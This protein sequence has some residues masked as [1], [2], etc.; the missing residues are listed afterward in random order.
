MPPYGS[1][2]VSNT[3]LQSVGADQVVPATLFNNESPILGQKSLACALQ[4]KSPM[5]EDFQNISVRVSC[6][7]GIGTTTIQVQTADFDADGEYTNE[8]TAI[9]PAD[10]NGVAGFGVA[11]KQ[12]QITRS[13]FL[14]V[15]IATANP[16]NPITVTVL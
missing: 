11:R 7:L 16:S 9:A 3:P 2:L 13:R 4:S 15:L 14:R 8:G 5:G 1:Q 10:F 6:P 12:L